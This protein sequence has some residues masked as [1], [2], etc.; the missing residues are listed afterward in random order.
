MGKVFTQAAWTLFAVSAGAL[1]ATGG[2]WPV[3]V[4]V[5]LGAIG[6]GSH[7]RWVQHRVPILR[8]DKQRLAAFY[9]SALE[10]RSALKPLRRQRTPGGWEEWNDRIAEWDSNFWPYIERTRDDWQPMRRAIRGEL[11]DKRYSN[12]ADI[13]LRMM[14]ERLALIERLMGE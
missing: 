13:G 3:A 7:S 10:L 5:V 6:A 2:A 8:T 1:A 12:W 4:A 9:A 14:D 11:P